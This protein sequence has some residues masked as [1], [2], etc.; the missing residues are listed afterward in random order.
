MPTLEYFWEPVAKATLPRHSHG[1]TCKDIT[2]GWLGCSLVVQWVKD[3]TLSLQW[4]ESLLWRR[5]D[6]WLR[7]F[8]VPQMWQKN[9]AKNKNQSNK[10]EQR[11]A[12]V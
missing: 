8:Y 5:F 2:T 4:L 10:K 12:V 1:A 11:Q 7:N 3:L 9:K 6:P